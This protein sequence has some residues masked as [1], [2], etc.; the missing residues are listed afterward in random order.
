MKGKETVNTTVDKELKQMF[1]VTRGIHHMG[2]GELLDKAIRELLIN[3]NQISF[4]EQEIARKNIEITKLTQEQIELT[5]VKEKI[6]NLKLSLVI[7]DKNNDSP[8]LNKLRESL[9]EKSKDSIL[10]LWS[11]GDI[12]WDSVI[13]KYKFQN[14]KEAEEWFRQ[15]IEEAER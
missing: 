4:I 10:K 11:R 12:N 6:Q 8:E 5:S 3:L 14:K 1:E 9:F 7:E 15:K 2:F 13:P